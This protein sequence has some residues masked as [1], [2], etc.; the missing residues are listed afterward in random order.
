MTNALPLS[1]RKFK[2]YQLN[3]TMTMREMLDKIQIWSDMLV[4]LKSSEKFKGLNSVEVVFQ[5]EN[6]NPVYKVL[7][8]AWSCAY[9][10]ESCVL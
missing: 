1:S 4:V 9:F 5:D 2:V 3:V 6:S 7:H 10:W 8:R